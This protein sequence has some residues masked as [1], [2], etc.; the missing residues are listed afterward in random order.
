MASSSPRSHGY[1]GLAEQ[2]S[3]ASG[4]FMK[5]G[6]FI[7]GVPTT[8]ES[9]SLANAYY[10]DYDI[11][12]PAVMEAATLILQDGDPEISEGLSG[13]TAGQAF[14]LLYGKSVKL[15]AVEEATADLLAELLKKATDTPMWLASAGTA[16]SEYAAP[17]VRSC[18]VAKGGTNL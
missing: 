11:L 16:A 5:G 12:W 9:W 15:V 1:G 3:A 6:M 13:G 7:E 18:L 8:D 10:K 14:R 4:L 2:M 17:L